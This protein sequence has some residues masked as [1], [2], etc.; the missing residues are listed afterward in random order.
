MRGGADAREGGPRP[1]QMHSDA[2]HPSRAGAGGDRVVLQPV[3]RRQEAVTPGEQKRRVSWRRG[4]RVGSSGLR[5]C[6]DR[7]TLNYEIA[8]E[9][10]EDL[11]IF[12][13]TVIK[14]ESPDRKRC[15][16]L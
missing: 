13:D 14:V 7:D 10:L 11:P 9:G 5:G 1:Q 15:R 4:R 8:M 2:Q 16:L 3:W 6:R 12:N